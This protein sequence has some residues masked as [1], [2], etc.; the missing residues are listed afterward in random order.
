MK[1]NKKILILTLN[2]ICLFSLASCQNTQNNQNQECLDDCIK[3]YL[4]GKNLS[5][6]GDSLSTWAGISNNDDYTDGLSLN[7]SY[8][9]TYFSSSYFTNGY[10][11]T[12]W[13]RLLKDYEM[14]LCVDNAW[15]GSYCSPHSP[16]QRADRDFPNEK[17]WYNSNAYTRASNLANK[18]GTTPDIIIFYIGMN[19]VNATLPKDTFLK[20]YQDTLDVLKTNYPNAKVYCINQ[21]DRTGCGEGNPTITDEILNTAKAYDEGISELLLKEEY[22]N[23]YL[24][25]QYNFEELKG[26]VY[27]THC[28]NDPCLNIHLDSSGHALLEKC[29]IE[30]IKTQL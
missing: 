14:N 21:P 30:S 27:R 12:Y 18:N 5:I 23:F 4:K 3:E 26:S 10:F 28:V 25:D 22:S 24:V 20:S 7:A 6:L 16:I 8:Y 2:A 29:I 11:D 1:I 15:S 13:G 19:D 17:G 9:N